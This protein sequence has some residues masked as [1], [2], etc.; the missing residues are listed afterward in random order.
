MISLTQ[1]LC[2]D[3]LHAF[4][5]EILGF[6][7]S[8]HHR[9]WY[10]LLDGRCYQDKV[11]GEIRLSPDGT[12]HDN[13]WIMLEAP[14]SHSKTTTFT[15]NYSLWEIARN[16]NIRIVIVSNSYT[17]STSFLREITSHIERN[18]RLK[19][20]Y[21]KIM[22]DNPTRWTAADIIVDRSNAKLKD[23]T[24]SATSIG[25]SVLARRADIIIS[26][27][28]LDDSN[29]RTLEQR[30]KTE[31][32]FWKVLLPVLEP[33]GRL[34]VV[35]T[36]WNVEDLYEKLL[37]S[38]EFSVRKKYKAIID[39]DKKEVMWKSRWSYETLMKLKGAMGSL[40]FN[41]AYQ[42]E[43][44]SAEDAVFKSEWLQ[45]AK[46]K[47]MQRTLINNLDYAKW[48]MGKLVVTAGVDLA[49]SQKK[50]SD[51]TAMAVIGQT[52]DG[53]KIPLWLSREK[54]TPAQTKSHIIALSERYNPDLIIVENNAYQ[55]ALRRD[56]ADTT[57]LPVKGYTTG[58]EKYDVDI[59]INSLAVEFEN[60]KWILPYS[61][62]DP[63]TIQM[64]DVL[65]DGLLRF[66]SGH[67]EDLVMALW[68]ANTGLRQL[69]QSGNTLTQ[70]KASDI[71][72]R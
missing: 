16:R 34:V 44:L 5:Q 56:L 28:I 18:E 72:G 11:T 17:Q 27:D 14:R 30:K 7:N 9:E 36:A 51:F 33:T 57:S 38:N 4:T 63:Y 47:G 55:E 71:F 41:Q 64:I 58:G 62:S 65:V 15:V 66:P 3:S 59:G 10:G 26:D 32:W 24:V 61:S 12:K 67:T 43:A 39:E 60:G 13:R 48:D 19:E 37:K 22:P 2:N 23:P 53:V 40:A 42:N 1:S 50:E 49:I 46:R 45:D 69:T 6:E 29:T 31:D 54:L 20:V 52:R 25:G 68:F 21:G 70:A 8:W 35:G